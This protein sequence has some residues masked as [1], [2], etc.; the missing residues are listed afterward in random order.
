MQAAWIGEVV[1]QRIERAGKRHEE[2]GQR[3]GDPDMALDG[4]AEEARTPLVLADGNERVPERRAQN[5]GHDADDDGE[6]DQHEIVERDVV[7]QQVDLEG[8]EIERLAREAAQTVVA[9]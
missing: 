7:V 2:T 9:A 6:A 4:N 1:A 3:E 5:E 8:A